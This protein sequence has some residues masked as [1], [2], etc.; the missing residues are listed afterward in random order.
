MSSATVTLP[1]PINVDH[2]KPGSRSISTKKTYNLGEFNLSSFSNDQVGLVAQ[3]CQPWHSSKHA[4]TSDINLIG[5]DWE[6]KLT[7][8]EHMVALIAVGGV[9]YAPLR[10]REYNGTVHHLVT[11]QNAIRVLSA[12]LQTVGPFDSTELYPQHMGFNLSNHGVVGGRTF[13]ET[14]LPDGQVLVGSNEAERIEY[15]ARYL[16]RNF[17][18]VDGVIFHRVDEPKIVVRPGVEKVSMFLATRR[19]DDSFVPIFNHYFRLDDYVRAVQMI[20]DRWPQDMISSQ[21]SELIVVDPEPLSNDFEV[22]EAVRLSRRYFDKLAPALQQLDWAT[23]E[24]WYEL[25]Q[26]LRNSEPDADD[27]DRLISLVDRSSKALQSNSEVDEDWRDKTVLYA[28]LGIER[29]EFR[30]IAFSGP[31]I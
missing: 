26:L 6:R 16:E 21:F 5:G 22:V 10:A 28:R 30:P 8:A 15:V 31:R 19:E 23:A 2:K 7:Q 14:G 12:G 17:I 24:P 3:W 25:K 9:F 27:V 20:E 18:A 1:V 13:A 11:T 29:W 4:T